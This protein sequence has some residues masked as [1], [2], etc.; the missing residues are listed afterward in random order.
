MSVP[1]VVIAGASSGV[2]KT[3]LATGIM[4]LLSKRMRVQGFKVGPDFIDPM[5][6]RAATG[7]PSRNLDSVF[8]DRG[9]LRNLFGWA[10]RDADVAVIEGVRG[11]YDGLTATGDEGSTAEIAK[12]LKAPVILV[13]NARSLAKSAAAHVLGF[14]ALDPEVHIA[15]VIL[16]QVSGPRHRQKAV[17]AVQSL[18]GTE[19]VGVVERRQE[20]LAER[21]LGLVTV[22][23]Q[24]VRETMR[25]IESYASELDLERILGIAESAPDIDFPAVSP[26]LK[27]DGA[28]V[29]VAVPRDKAF[30]FYYE[31]NLESL[32]C[33][34][35][36]I[37]FYSPADGD[38][39]PEADAHYLGGG[40]PEIYQRELS[41]NLDF[42]EGIGR[43]SAEG[44]L[45]Y[46][47]CGGMMALCRSIVYGGEEWQMA[48]VFPYRA[49][50]TTHRQGLAYVRAR[51]TPDNPLFPGVE[52]VAHEFHYSR[53]LPTP[54]GPYVYEVL[55]GTG[56]DGSHDGLRMRNT[57][58]T[59]MHQ[60]ALANKR[61]GT[62]MVSF[63]RDHVP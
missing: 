7:R 14:K 31:E 49:E 35:A 5:F 23:E 2:G 58:G 36:E 43:A 25:I 22:P 10:T 39:L 42:L 57:I 8:M 20:R 3:T 26:F 9:T 45:I 15:G 47:E 12:I 16:N 11:L 6:H 34:G 60:H 32:R 40:Y 51:A 27:G 28:R 41:S 24:D 59:Y 48:D 17:E 55:R 44:K 18:T 4:S 54:S 56:I 61:W 30:S 52:I 21:H 62:G 37:V 38:S 63:I 50:L 33:A 29:K 19:V 13:V 46:G 53:L 1:R